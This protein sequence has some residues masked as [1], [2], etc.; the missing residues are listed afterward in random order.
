MG[1]K[2][3]GDRYNRRGSWR[4][5]VAPLQEVAQAM[6]LK[7]A[8]NNREAAPGVDTWECPGVPPAAYCTSTSLPHARHYVSQAMGVCEQCGERYPLTPRIASRFGFC[9][10]TCVGLYDRRSDDL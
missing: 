4:T 3:F 7:G 10:E 1:S 2:A 9:S 6:V 5:D 8:N